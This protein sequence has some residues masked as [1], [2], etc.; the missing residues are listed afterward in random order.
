MINKINSK[1]VY[2]VHELWEGSQ[3]KVGHLLILGGPAPQ[4]AD[5]LQTMFDGK[6]QLV[7]NYQVANAIG[8]A[9]ARTTCEVILFADTAQGKATSPSEGFS[10]KI[11]FNFSLDDARTLAHD[12]LRKKAIQRGANPSDMQ[13]EVLEESQF[14]MIRGFQTIGKN[15]RI[16]MQVKPGL[17]R[18][19]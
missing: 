18:A 3:I 14:N 5:R 8:C 13:T 6:V 1:P 12:L 9:L 7:P 15:M 16:R 4:F 10:Q 19:K 11:P 17:I 2:T